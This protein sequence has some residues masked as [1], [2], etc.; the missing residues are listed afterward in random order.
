MTLTK[1]RPKQKPLPPRNKVK[2]ADTWNLATLF[3]DDAAWEAE[4]AKWEKQIKKFAKFRG[5]LGESAE[6][7][8]ACL[9]FDA[10]FKP[11]EKVD[12]L[13]TLE[14]G[15]AFYYYRKAA[16]EETISDP[17]ASLFDSA[18]G[19][20]FDLFIRWRPLSDVGI[21]INYGVFLPGGAYDTDSDDARNFISL[22]ITYTF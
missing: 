5:T 7:L 2:E 9:K 20:E 18:I 3:I 11:F 19:T 16:E 12:L 4:F 14:I 1:S 6:K 22:G 10:A 8:A 13:K 15:A 17:R 21:S